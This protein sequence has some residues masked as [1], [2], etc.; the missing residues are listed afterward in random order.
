MI[1]IDGMNDLLFFFFLNCRDLVCM[2]VVCSIMTPFLFLG[3]TV[4]IL[5]GS[6]EQCLRY[7]IM[8]YEYVRQ[9]RLCKQSKQPKQM[10]PSVSPVLGLGRRKPPSHSSGLK[11]IC[12]L[13]E[14]GG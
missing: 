14:L 3:I 8:V 10:S 13:K 6:L 11:S 4:P 1:M 9:T 12:A 2:Y 7:F 5:L